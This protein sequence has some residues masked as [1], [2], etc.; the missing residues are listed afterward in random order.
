MPRAPRAWAK[1]APCSG[2]VRAPPGKF[3]ASRPPQTVDFT[4]ILRFTAAASAYTAATRRTA[5]APMLDWLI[6][7]CDVFGL[8]CQNWMLALAGALII[9]LAALAV[10]QKRQPH[11]H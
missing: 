6:G 10:L 9:Y 1:R 3:Y 2:I 7:S 5:K 11:V 8:P 4:R